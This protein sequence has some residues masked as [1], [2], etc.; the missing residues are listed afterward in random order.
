[1]VD[2]VLMGNCVAFIQWV[3][4]QCAF[5][6]IPM[7]VH[8]GQQAREGSQPDLPPQAPEKQVPDAPQVRPAPSQLTSSP[9]SCQQLNA[10]LG[11]TRQLRGRDPAPRTPPGAPEPSQDV[12][13]HPPPGLGATAKKDPREEQYVYGDAYGGPQGPFTQRGADEMVARLATHWARQPTVTT[14]SPNDDNNDPPDHDA[15][16]EKAPSSDNEPKQPGVFS[17]ITSLFSATQT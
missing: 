15:V 3:L 1:M 9:M 4:I 16:E 11:D 17:R 2:V 12:N 6:G 7:Q 13:P 14:Q 8:E 10:N 5:K